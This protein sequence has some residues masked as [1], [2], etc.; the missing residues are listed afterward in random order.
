MTE[1]T[2]SPEDLAQHWIFKAS[3]LATLL[4]GAL[5]ALGVV[6]SVLPK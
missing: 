1:S 3:F 4:M 5:F 6:L 2:A